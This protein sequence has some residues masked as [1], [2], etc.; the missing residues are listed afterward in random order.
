MSR[1]ALVVGI[2]NYG[3]RK[4]LNKPATDAEAI[5][6]FLENKGNFNVTRLPQGINRRT[7]EP[8]VLKD[9]KV[10]CK[11]LKK[12]LIQLFKPQGETRQIPE[13]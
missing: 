12:A 4:D 2:N 11:Q 5:A 7:N 8:Y 13:K 1:D 10:R 9:E 6:Q 3:G